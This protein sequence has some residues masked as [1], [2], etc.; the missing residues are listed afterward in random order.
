MSDTDTSG[1]EAKTVQNIYLLEQ[2]GEYPRAVIRLD[3]SDY[4]A[5]KSFEFCDIM[6]NN[7]L[8]FKGKVSSYTFENE[9][10]EIELTSDIK[11]DF[12]PEKIRRESADIVEKF[13]KENPELFTKIST[14]EFLRTGEKVYSEIKKP[15]E[16]PIKIDNK[17]I[18][19]TL[20][21][22]KSIDTSLSEIN[23]MLKAAW[24]SR[25]DGMIPL[26]T[27]IE[28]RFKMSRINTIT[29]KTSERYFPN[30]CGLFLKPSTAI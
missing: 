28:K 26:S 24:I 18:D 16:A 2:E 11:G 25:R 19:G 23:L 7:E 29:P 5:I 8:F 14:E 20:K 12:C 15:T 9:E 22:K 27:K 6:R 4:K 10:M 21:I 1:I 17:V 13:K 3:R 30:S